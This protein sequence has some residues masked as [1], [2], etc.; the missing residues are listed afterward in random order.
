MH[1]VA[2]TGWIIAK[3]NKLGFDLCGIASVE[4]LADTANLKE[5]L[6]R[7][8]AGQMQYMHD[9]RRGGYQAGASGD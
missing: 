5:W 1:G 6:A 4:G 2:E 9:P 8:Y 3:A 7:G